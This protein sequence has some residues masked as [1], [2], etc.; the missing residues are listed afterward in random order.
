MSTFERAQPQSRHSTHTA[1]ASNRLRSSLPFAPA[2][3]GE[4]F[5]ADQ[6][7]Q[8]QHGTRL[9]HSLAN[10]PI[11]SDGQQTDALHSASL[12]G[13]L[14]RKRIQ[15]ARSNGHPLEKQVQHQLERGLGMDLSGVRVHIDS[16]ADRLTQALNATAFTTRA[17]IFFRSGM[18]QPSTTR[19]MYL[20]AHEATHTIQQVAGQ[21]DEVPIANGVLVSDPED[22]FE[23]A[24]E[25]SAAR[26]T[27]SSIH[28]SQAR[29]NRERN[30]QALP[31]PGH[32]QRSDAPLFVQRT[33]SDAR[34]YASRNYT[35]ESQKLKTY[36]A[37]N[38]AD[39]IARDVVVSVCRDQRLSLPWRK[40]LL[41][42]YN[43][44]NT[45]DLLPK[46]ILEAESAEGGSN[47][48]Q[49]EGV[50]EAKQEE[51][52]P[53]SKLV[54]RKST[55]SEQEEGEP[56]KKAKEEDPQS[57]TGSKEN[58][59][60]GLASKF[61]FGESSAQQH[62]EK[63]GSEE[64]IGQITEEEYIKAALAFKKKSRNMLTQKGH[65]GKQIYFEYDEKEDRG[66][67]LVYESSIGKI[68]TYYSLNN[69]SSKLNGFKSAID[70]LAKKTGYS[71]QEI[72]EMLQS[73]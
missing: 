57:V 33:L 18:Y 3:T 4:H 59:P 45:E 63:H 43:K 73:R 13:D 56:T 62:F 25:G 1:S 6:Q 58:F 61:S 67:L 65:P 35:K 31:Q 48:P 9:R 40:G 8:L 72:R 5:S 11:V 37:K 15:V 54:K 2:P 71:E 44:D 22:R 50:S 47:Q 36:F 28:A 64:G 52:T 70:Q 55:A 14:L 68:N 30:G 42:A 7:T 49:T 69:K 66:Q 20:L 23:Q 38:D 29:A 27:E 12:K 60:E 19:G 17:D 24:A 16:E 39:V 53:E 46:V 34:R 10:I 21:V 26:I 32:G 51:E 41:E